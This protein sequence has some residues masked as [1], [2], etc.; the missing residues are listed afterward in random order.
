M[1]RKRFP[2]SRGSVGN[3]PPAYLRDGETVR[4][5]VRAARLGISLISC[6]VAEPGGWEKYERVSREAWKCVLSSFLWRMEWRGGMEGLQHTYELYSK[7]HRFYCTLAM[8]SYKIYITE[9]RLKLAST[10]LSNFSLNRWV[11][12]TVSSQTQIRT[13]RVF[14][15][16]DRD[17]APRIV[18]RMI[19]RNCCEGGRTI[20]EADKRMV[21]ER[22]FK[23]LKRR[24]L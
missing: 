20:G 4:V 19:F 24:L 5:S 10:F 15:R 18:V 21:K 22:K 8:Y 12:C 1:S 16:R 9:M 6:A 13:F 7:I 23:V 17:L 3:E 14:T 2:R 11:A